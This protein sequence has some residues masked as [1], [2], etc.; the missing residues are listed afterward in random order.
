MKDQNYDSNCSP[1]SSLEEHTAYTHGKRADSIE[2]LKKEKKKLKKE[3]KKLKKYVKSCISIKSE[4]KKAKKKG[5]GKKCKKKIRNLKKKQ[6]DLQIRY[7]KVCMDAKYQEKFYQLFLYLLSG[8]QLSKR[9]LTSSWMLPNF[10]ER[11][12]IVDE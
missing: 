12:D 3:K 8:G 5:S 7:D 2:E 1:A 9:N 11:K 4:G 6:A 10:L